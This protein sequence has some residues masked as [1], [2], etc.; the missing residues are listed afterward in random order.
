MNLQKAVGINNKGQ[1]LA[2]AHTITTFQNHALVL[3]PN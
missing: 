2:E 1:V 3:N